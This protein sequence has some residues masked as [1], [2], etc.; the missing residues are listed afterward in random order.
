M[1]SP[2]AQ[3]L[4]ERIQDEEGVQTQ[5]D[6][7]VG[8]YL[9]DIGHALI[10]WLDGLAR[11]AFGQEVSETT[12]WLAVAGL[13]VLLLAA[14]ITATMRL[15][16]ARRR[17]R[18]RRRRDRGRAVQPDAEEPGPNPRLQV[19]GLLSAGRTRDALGA[20]WSWLARGLA[21]QGHGS[22]APDRTEREFVA[23]LARDWPG[24]PAVQR[25]ARVVVRG[26][27]G[28]AA[29]DAADVERLVPVVEALLAP[30]GAPA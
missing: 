4:L 27:Y 28:T 30:P 19:A 8:A 12:L 15:R 24:R 17:T 9:R 2:E 13:T 25:V 21:D 23:T 29:P 5:V 26:V 1:S 11:D 3:V 6:A 14:V 22:W 7:S 20:L 10:R 18:L 16:S